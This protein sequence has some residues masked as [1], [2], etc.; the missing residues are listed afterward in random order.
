MT[1]DHWFQPKKD[2]IKIQSD[3]LFVQTA[4]VEELELQKNDLDKLKQQH[5]A[6]AEELE[7]Q[8][9]DLDKLKQQHQAQ[10]EELITV[11]ARTNITENQV[12]DLKRG[13]EVK[14]VA[15][16][17]SLVTSGGGDIGPF[18]TYTPLIFKNVVTNIGNAYNKN[19]GH[20]TAPVKGI[21]HFEFHIYGHG[22]ASHGSGA[23]LVKNEE[24]I[25]NAY[26]HQ[27]SHG[28]NSANS[29]TLLLDV[30]DVVFL[31]QRTNTRVFD[32][33]YHYTSFSGHL[34]FTT[35]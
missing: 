32:D 2:N 16:S 21:Y 22:H 29:V 5:Q 34:L 18:N 27:P 6:K 12:E 20:F 10:A 11:K 8:K 13:G 4:R 14:R 30:G 1:R 17:T 7:L 3:L 33:H 35:L 19:T 9:N 15:F 25:F 26:E 23:V 24:R 28:A 31:L